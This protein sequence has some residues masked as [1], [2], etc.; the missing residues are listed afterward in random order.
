[1]EQYLFSQCYAQM[2]QEHSKNILLEYS[3]KVL[4]LSNR[5][6]Y[7]PKQ[8]IVITMSLEDFVRTGGN[9]STSCAPLKRR[10]YIKALAALSLLVPGNYEFYNPHPKSP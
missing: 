8:Y 1:M 5:T 2:F 3:E 6:K 4:T 7:K 9:N 10:S